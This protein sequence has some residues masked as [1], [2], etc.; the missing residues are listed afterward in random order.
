VSVAGLLGRL[1]DRLNPVVVRELRQAV[2]SRLVAVTLLVFLAL[3]LL[4]LGIALGSQVWTQA[5]ES[6]DFRAGRTVF[7]ILQGV[8]LATCML[9]VPA[10]AGV[11]LALERSDTNVDLLFIS[12]L[13][14]RKIIAG[15]CIA[16]VT[17]ILL[18]FSAC[19]PFLTFSYLLRGLDIPTVLSVL[20]FD[21]LSVLTATQVFLFLAAVPTNRWAKGMLLLAGLVGLLLLLW[22]SVMLTGMWLFEGGPPLRYE[23]WEFWSA[24]ASM[25]GVVLAI[26]G[27]FFT[28]SVALVTPP[29]ANRAMGPRLYA[30]GLWA[31]SGVLA[32]VWAARI[33]HNGPVYTWVIGAVTLWMLQGLIAANEREE[34]G[35]RVARTIPRRWWLRVP[36][37]LLYSG[38]AGGLLLAAGAVAATI[39][40]THLWREWHPITEGSKELANTAAVMGVAA[41]Y[42]GA[43]LLTA[44]VARR[45]CGILAALYPRS[46]VMVRLARPGLTWLIALLLVGAFSVLP[47]TVAYM[48]MSYHEL[49]DA[50]QH[51]PPW[52]TLSNPFSAVY[53][54]GEAPYAG[55]ANGFEW[56][57]PLFAGAWVALG[58]LVNLPWAFAQ[59]RRFRPR[60][61]VPTVP[62]AA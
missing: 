3:Q 5:V 59:V 47:Y 26:L 16:A 11:R 4:V 23:S 54:Y 36:A 28:W 45:G 1:D 7:M 29:S 20:G 15:K 48:T 14:P 57:C 62:V 25:V 27:L 40:A 56:F 24:V 31:A 2:Q 9:L 30:L 51:G 42:E 34:W 21:F 6:T 37:F 41:L 60:D 32:A 12:T 39:L 13:K 55:F 50:Y 46:P 61:E 44:L 33:E 35:P 38:S 19:A 10:Y 17:L 58:A 22:G 18:I 52:W 49:R 8:M 43:F 53:D